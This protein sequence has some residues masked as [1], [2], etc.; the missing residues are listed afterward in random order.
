MNISVLTRFAEVENSAPINQVWVG[1]TVEDVKQKAVD[2][3]M[4]EWYYAF[5]PKEEGEEEATVDEI[6]NAYVEFWDGE[7]L[8]ELD[9]QKI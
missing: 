6:F 2:A 5:N 7:E 9:E 3:V 4:R 1:R 8:F